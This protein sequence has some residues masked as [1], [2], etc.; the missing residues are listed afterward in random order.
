[1]SAS[2][3][4][5]RPLEGWQVSTGIGGSFQAESVATFDW[6]QWQVSTGISGNLRAE[7]AARARAHERE[8]ADRRSAFG[9]KPENI[10]SL[11]A[12]LLLTMPDC[13][14]TSSFEND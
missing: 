11:R 14:P 10:V 1:M 8:G 2:P 6:N 4:A 9:A 5:P 3:R 12:L 13:R 7:Y